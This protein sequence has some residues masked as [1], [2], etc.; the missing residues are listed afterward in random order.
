MLR[1]R[2][3]LGPIAALWLVCQAAT[4][5]LV[6]A[7]FDASLADCTCTQGAGAACPMHQKTSSGTKVCV[8]HSIT[9]SGVALLDALF[10]VAGLVPAPSPAA[11][12]VLTSRPLFVDRSIA[13]ERHAPPDPPPPRA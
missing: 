9:T 8:M 5:T 4:L 6:P 12:R 3:A 2:I 1:V 7:L 11:A 13:T 10:S